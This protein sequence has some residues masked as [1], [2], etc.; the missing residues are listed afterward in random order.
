MGEKT[1]KATPKKLRDAKKK[2]QVAKSQ[3][4][5]S[6]FTFVT[7]IALIL[8]LSGF[9]FS[10]VGGFIESTFKLVSH[11]EISVVIPTM[12]R[13]ALLTIFSTVI[14]VMAAVALMGVVVNF[15][16]VG[17]V[18]ATEVFKFDIKKFDPIQNLKSKF[19]I[20]TL[21]ELIKSCLKIGIA[22][23]LIYG[24]MYK[25]LPVLTQAATM[26][27]ESSLLIFKAFLMEVVIKVG[28]FF[29]VVAVLDFAYQKYNFGKEM[30]MEKF[31]VKQ[32][33]KNTEG[34]PQIKSKRKQTAQEIA[35][36]D[37]PAAAVQKAAA[38]I[39]NPV[40]LAIAVGY[41]REIDAAPYILVMGEGILAERIVH[42]ANK[43]EVPIVRNIELAH[44]L[45]LE[46]EIFE[47]IPEDT[48][49]A[50]AEILRWIN[51]LEDEFDLDADHDTGQVSS[52]IAETPSTK[53]IDF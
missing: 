36:S 34:D 7:S 29:L 25:S 38:V 53:K 42:Y 24:V 15:L 20:K 22:A 21:V 49:E 5:P 1:E 40:Q 44:K 12:F 2:G 10:K 48:Y 18:W 33:Y 4:F 23:W 27:I 45:W 52:G 31:E 41:N 17:P 6:A 50:M 14:P 47:Y 46:G 8:G 9:M 35:Y 11:D 39:T 19:K 43:S 13:E 32:E 16:S 28:I 3:D 26:P 51:S 30:M 37:G